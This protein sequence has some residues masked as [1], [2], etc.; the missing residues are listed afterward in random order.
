MKN[1]VKNLWP[2]I[3]LIL[4]ISGLLLLTERNDDAGNDR[5]KPW[6]V[7]IFKYSSRAALDETENGYIESLA[8][9]G[10][11]NG[12]K[13]MLTRYN[14]ENDMATANAI[15]TE[16]VNQKFD[17]VITA[18]TPCLQVMANANKAGK[19]IHV[20]GTVT[21]PFGAGVGISRMDQSKRPP[22]MAG[23]GTFQPVKK[24]F[25]I[26]REMNPALKKV[27]VVWCT[28]QTCSEACVVIA[29]HVCD[30]LGIQL[31]ENTVENSNDVY[32]A[33]K[34]LVSRGA[35]ALWIGGDNTVEVA[36][37]MV[38]KAGDEGNIPVFTNNTDH[39]KQGAIFGLGANYY[40]VGLSVGKIAAQI[41]D[42]RKPLEFSIK[43]VVPEKLVVNSTKLKKYSD[44][45]W[46][47]TAHLKSTTSFIQ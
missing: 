29:R 47:M 3:T 5:N 21:D 2:P 4:V 32:E 17:M 31:L 40:D 9:N 37:G 35:E 6:R 15:A 38:I 23:A 46:R 28:S 18:S 19:V 41:L 27:G 1:L 33:A 42:G 10:Y 11:K 25:L 43:N 22:W 7:A 24:A 13:M 44:I 45:S 14:A 16:I 30:S 36:S 8:Q 20:F 26:A 39:P 12:G 34:A